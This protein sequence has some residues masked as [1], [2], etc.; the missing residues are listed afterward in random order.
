MAVV[1]GL[2]GSLMRLQI[3]MAF[4]LHSQ[5]RICQSV[6]AQ[7]EGRGSLDV[8]VSGSFSAPSFIPCLQLVHRLS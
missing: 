5:Q 3:L 2:A 7:E 8:G 4:S 1:M 6:L